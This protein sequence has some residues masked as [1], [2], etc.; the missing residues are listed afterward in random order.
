[1]GQVS[2]QEG[3][4]RI[5]SRPKNLEYL[6]QRRTTFLRQ[7]L[8]RADRVLEIGAG[9]GIVSL[10]VPGARVVSTDVHSGEWLQTVADAMALPFQSG[11]FD[12]VVCLNVL[13]HLPHPCRALEGMA[14]VIRAGGLLLIAEPHASLTLQL[15]L[16]LTGHEYVDTS[17]DPFGNA[18]CQTCEDPS[19]DGN[20]AIGDLLFDDLNR[21]R[22]AFPELQ[23]EHHRL[24]ECVSFLNSGGVGFQVPFLPLPAWML[25]MVGKLDDWLARFPHMF[26]LCREVVLRKRGAGEEGPRFWR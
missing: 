9:W 10:Y 3:R 12:A 18:S 6:L 8:Q 21:F 23:V 2:L 26:P 13:H 22:Q 11:T 15:V 5:L 19:A 25:Q 20:N 1:M 16:R 7:H 24:T 4:A 14:R 17:V